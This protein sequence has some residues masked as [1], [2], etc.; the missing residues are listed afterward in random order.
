[1]EI[2]NSEML[3]GTLHLICQCTGGSVEPN[4]QTPEGPPLLGRHPDAYVHLT[5][6]AIK[7]EGGL[8]MELEGFISQMPSKA[9]S[10]D[11]LL[12]ILDDSYKHAILAQK[13]NQANMV[14]SGQ[15]LSDQ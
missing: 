4:P 2:S 12:Q 10:I 5:L 11:E 1:M 15:D 13:F 8:R 14:V 9:H 7:E 3:F 6:N